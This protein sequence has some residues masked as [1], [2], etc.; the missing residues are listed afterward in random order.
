M[1]KR[2]L[3]LREK[4]STQIFCVALIMSL[5]A[6]SFGTRAQAPLVAPV[7]LSAQGTSPLH[8]K[9]TFTDTNV[10]DDFYDVHFTSAT[11]PS[12]VEIWTVD[13][14]NVPDGEEIE[15][16][17]SYDFG[18]G[19]TVYVKVRAAIA[20]PVTGEYTF[21]PFS[22][23][24]T[25]TALESFPV[26]PSDFEAIAEEDYIRLTWTDNSP[27]G[28][29]WDETTFNIQRSHISS[30]DPGWSI[31]VLANTNSF[32]DT[33]VNPGVTYQYRL[34][35]VNE[36]GQ[37]NEVFF[38][39]AR[40]LTPPLYAPTAKLATFVSGTSF[41]ANW[42]TADGATSYKLYVYDTRDSS[43]LQ[44]YN[45]MT[46]N[47]TSIQVTGAKSYRT[48]LY[49]VTSVNQFEESDPS[50][51]ILVS[52]IRDLT[53]RSVCSPD[54]EAYRR[55][56]IIN[57]NPIAVDVEWTVLATGEEGSLSALPG[58]TFFTTVTAT[59]NYT[60][61]LNYTVIKWTDDDLV[62]HSSQKSSTT[63]ECAAEVTIAD[64]DM[65]EERGTADAL[66]LNA[67]PNT[68]S[69]KLTLHV[70]AKAG[71]TAYVEIS[72]HFGRKVL[73]MTIPVNTDV[74]VDASTFRKG[75]YI[76]KA[77]RKNS[78]KTMRILKE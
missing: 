67:Y 20:D 61:R 54:P 47:D 63:N 64:L 68:V 71:K 60:S 66:T 10:D 75:L 26:P 46:A 5:C 72:D 18:P 49:H 51:T 9:V 4:L 15:T 48:Y 58:E 1:K 11:D 53:L 43:F 40:A 74:E 22:E 45:G 57:N 56:K 50:N 29:E 70:S 31:D 6:T 16:T 44:G 13:S 39:T 35:A 25:A 59:G 42:K 78:G 62:E 8:F 52:R 76:V 41:T 27:P 3:S 34:S 36:F 69:N 32:I 37:N 28:H 12:Y 73:S 2:V 17:A 77:G 38:A 14:F 23:T 19:G 21:G 55:W 24:V 30:Q 65:E 7:N 33:T